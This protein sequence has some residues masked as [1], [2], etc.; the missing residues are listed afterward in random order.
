MDKEPDKRKTKHRE[1]LIDRLSKFSGE[2]SILTKGKLN[3]VREKLEE[4]QTITERLD[5][6]G[7]DMEVDLYEN[8]GTGKTNITG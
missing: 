7:D 6:W 8:K 1:S 4:E 2:K 5:R 3:R